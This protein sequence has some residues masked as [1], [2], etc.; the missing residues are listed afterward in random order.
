MFILETQIFQ[1]SLDGKK[2]QTM[3]Q[4]CI[5]VERLPGYLDLFGRQH[6]TQR[7]HVMQAVGNLDQNHPDVITHGQE[8]FPEILGLG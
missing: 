1:F 2:S 6:R 4:R 3:R 5:E 7:T 8:Q